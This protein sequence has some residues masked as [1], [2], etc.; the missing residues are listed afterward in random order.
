[1]FDPTRDIFISGVGMSGSRDLVGG[2]SG[3]GAAQHHTTTPQRPAPKPGNKKSEN[4][5]FLDDPTPVASVGPSWTPGQRRA[6]SSGSTTWGTRRWT[7]VDN[8]MGYI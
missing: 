7:H 1:M 5:A 6:A 2:G 4:W 3:G 8:T